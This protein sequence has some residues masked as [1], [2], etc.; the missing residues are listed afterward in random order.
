M[1]KLILVLITITF[2]SCATKKNCPAYS[3]VITEDGINWYTYDIVNGDSV[4]YK[5]TK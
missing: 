3:E 2:M 5:K 1:K 4:R